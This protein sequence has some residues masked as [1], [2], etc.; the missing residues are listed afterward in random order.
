MRPV[1]DLDDAVHIFELEM[2]EDLSKGSSIRRLTRIIEAVL[3]ARDNPQRA[4]WQAAGSEPLYH[5][6]VCVSEVSDCCWRE[7]AVHAPRGGDNSSTPTGSTP[8]GS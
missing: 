6:S 4:H 1:A 3:G 5:R 8:T 2:I 7:A